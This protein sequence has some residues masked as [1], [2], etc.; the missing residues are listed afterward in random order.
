[1]SGY[2][3]KVATEDYVTLLGKVLKGIDEARRSI[4]EFK[5]KSLEALDRTSKKLSKI[6]ALPVSS[7]ECVVVDPT[8]RFFS[9][10]GVSE[11]NNHL[12]YV[13]M[14]P[15]IIP[16]F[17]LVSSYLVSRGYTLFSI[18][19]TS[20]VVS[21][22]GFFTRHRELSAVVG[23]FIIV[24]ELVDLFVMNEVSILPVSY[25]YL[26]LPVTSENTLY[27][28]TIGFS[29]T[30]LEDEPNIEI[31][32]DEVPKIPD[33]VLDNFISLKDTIDKLVDR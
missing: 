10:L 27:Y 23:H 33:E 2:T 31:V 3:K 32:L 15:P 22:L 14:K 17:F 18:V 25:K 6:P 21:L 8:R 11:L 24:P 16:H 13:Y 12:L 20:P 26:A 4:V 7:K 30:A 28:T 9:S 19:K 29:T 1:M 5:V